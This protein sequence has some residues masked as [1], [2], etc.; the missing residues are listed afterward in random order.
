M[1][2]TT[3]RAAAMPWQTA[4]ALAE[5][6]AAPLPAVRVALRE[7]AGRRLAEPLRS[8]VPV[9]GFDTDTHGLS[10]SPESSSQTHRPSAV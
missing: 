8:L 6:V 1:T 5:G 9:P 10:P 2:V 7:A 4:R 3:A